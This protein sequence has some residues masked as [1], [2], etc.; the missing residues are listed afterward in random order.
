MIV[1]TTERLIIRYYRESD[2]EGFAEMCADPDVMLHFPKTM[3]KS[4]SRDFF[5]RLRSRLLDIGRTFWAL[6]LKESGEFIG[7]TGLSDPNFEAD[8][9]PCVEIGWRLRKRFWNKG[10]ATEAATACLVVGWEQYALDEI[11]SM[12]VVDNKA[13][14]HVMQ[15]IGMQYVK[16][17]M[18]PALDEYPHLQECVLFKIS[19]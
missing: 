1:T 16:N 19:R 18:H 11:L 2:F 9:I 17:F 6:E 15:K 10:Y 8:F 13:S 7:F 14:I 3:S 5:E 12:A 4:E